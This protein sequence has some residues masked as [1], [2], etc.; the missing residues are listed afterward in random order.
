MVLTSLKDLP[1]EEEIAELLPQVEEIEEEK[2]DLH[3]ITD[4]LSEKNLAIPYAQDE[5]ENQKLKDTLKSI[6]TT[7]DF[8]KEEKKKSKKEES[9]V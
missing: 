5:Q 8:L 4:T 6:P 7:V 2:E 9:P 3:Q 1:S